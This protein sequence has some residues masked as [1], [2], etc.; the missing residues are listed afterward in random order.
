MSEF[1]GRYIWYELMT[2]DVAGAK[3]FY[4]Q[5]VGWTSRDM[6][7]PGMTYTIVEADGQGVG[8]MMTIPQEVAAS[9]MPPNWTG[10][11]AVDDVDATAAQVKSLGGAVHREPED[12]P[13]IGRFAII[14]DP[15]GAALAVM[16]PAPMDEPRPPSGPRDAG[17]TGW[18]ELYGG[19][20]DASLAFY[21]QLFGWRKDDIF[22]MG[23]M[24]PYLLFANQQGQIGGMMRRPAQVPVSAWIYYFN[25]GDID[26]A[27]GRVTSAGGTIM[28]GPMEVPGGEWVLQG[29][30]PQGAVFALLGRKA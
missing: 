18:H 9:G 22:D 7:M 2:P 24:G 6:P 30:D 19:E 3:T 15:A 1:H 8:G 25:V 28:M 13:G 17:H 14:A 12:I 10:Y 5:V 27:A 23:E 29:M 11:V 20:P 16:T 26:E 21:S 4:G